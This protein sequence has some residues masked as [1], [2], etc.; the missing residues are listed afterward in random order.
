MENRNSAGDEEEY[1]C[2]GGGEN[3]NSEKDLPVGKETAWVT[4]IE[5][6]ARPYAPEYQYPESE[7]DSSCEESYDV[8]KE[9]SCVDTLSLCV[10]KAIQYPMRASIIFSTLLGLI[11]LAVCYALATA[12]CSTVLG[13]TFDEPLY[14]GNT[15]LTPSNETYNIVLFGD[16]LVEG[17]LTG[18]GLSAK[19][20][21]FLP[22]WKINVENYG[23][24]GSRIND[25][26]QRMDN[27]LQNTK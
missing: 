18:G 7:S 8:E 26:R 10:D 16:S 21:Q 23:R 14:Y 15:F 22:A 11:A 19:M 25:M 2:G 17:P 1:Q 13:P 6:D 27:M 9:T 4:I 5:V 3:Q 12:Q 20:S 24:S